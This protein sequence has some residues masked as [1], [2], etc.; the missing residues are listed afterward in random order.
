MKKVFSVLIAL[1]VLSF[2]TATICVAVTPKR[3]D[4]PTENWSFGC[5]GV[6]SFRAQADAET[7]GTAHRF[8]MGKSYAV[9]L[10]NHTDHAQTV[11]ICRASDRKV[12][13]SFSIPAGAEEFV[14]TFYAE[15]MWYPEFRADSFFPQKCD[16]S[17][18]IEEADG[19]FL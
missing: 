1:L 6:Y 10:T 9:T 16:L 18:T 17:I 12:L 11:N 14:Y 13:D 2:V 4:L 7:I 8:S 19:R 5:E 15:N 3:A